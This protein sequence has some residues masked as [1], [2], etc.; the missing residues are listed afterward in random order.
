MLT[1]DEDQIEK[2]GLKHVLPKRRPTKGGGKARKLKLSTKNSLQPETNNQAQWEWPGVK[3]SDGDKRNIFAHVVM[4]LVQVFCE[5]QTY[6]WRGRIYCQVTGLPIGPRGTSAV[7]R[8]VMNMLDRKFKALM[9]NWRLE[10]TL[11]I[12]FIDDVRA[13]L[14][15]LKCGLTVGRNGRLMICEEKKR[16]DLEDENPVLKRGNEQDSSWDSFHF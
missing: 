10:M 7:A 14:K 4:C 1:L 5:T 6:S 9:S 16:I 13:M 3:L 8:T 15:G 2:S 12:R 11:L